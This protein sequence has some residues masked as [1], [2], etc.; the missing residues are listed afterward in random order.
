MAARALKPLGP[1]SVKLYDDV[2]RRA[3]GDNLPANPPYVIP[4]GIAG[5]T[6]SNKALLR[7]AVK[8]R[9][10]EAR[11]PVNELDDA[12][13][14]IPVDWAASRVTEIPTE[15][16]AQ[17]YEEICRKALPPGKRAM[18]LLPLALGLRARETISLS[19][20]AVER[21]T[22]YG[23]LTFLRK[24]GEEQTLDAAHMK[25]LFEELLSVRSMK[26]NSLF[27]SALLEG[28][29]WKIT[30]QIL[31]TGNGDAAYHALHRM[32]AA[33]GEEAG[34]DDLHPHKL[35]HA[36]ATRMHRDGAPLA[37]IQWMLNHASVSTTM[38]YIHPGKTDAV[39]FM[40]KF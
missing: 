32:I 30:G 38:R 26:R 25:P 40:R 28:K 21:A 33:M 11:R 20:R 7:A 18:A 27:E 23:E 29:P 17:K 37:V 15:E 4:E 12:L 3:F 16:E 2:L 10:M 22:Q 9:Y 35:R 19:R 6:G 5:W 8:R 14:A 31:S 1:V 24:G 34:I 13:D 39:K 36:F